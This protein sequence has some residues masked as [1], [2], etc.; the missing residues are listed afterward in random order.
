MYVFVIRPHGVLSAQQQVQ[1]VAQGCL[2]R[3]DERLP[4]NLDIMLGVLTMSTSKRQTTSPRKALSLRLY[5]LLPCE[6]VLKASNPRWGVM[7]SMNTTCGPLCVSQCICLADK[8]ASEHK[9][10]NR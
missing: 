8:Q 7:L 9:P 5:L 10:G 1:P 2:H 3:H 4:G 6:L